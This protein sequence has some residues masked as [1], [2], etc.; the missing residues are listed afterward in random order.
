MTRHP[1]FHGVLSVSGTLGAARGFQRLLQRYLNDEWLFGNK[2]NEVSPTSVVPSM[3]EPSF[4]ELP[5]KSKELDWTRVL[6]FLV[7]QIG[8]MDVRLAVAIVVLAVVGPVL[9]YVFGY[10]EDTSEGTTTTTTTTATI[11]TTKESEIVASHLDPAQRAL[12]QFGKSKS[13]PLL[14]GY[15]SMKL[16]EI[17]E[18]RNA[19]QANLLRRQLQLE[20]PHFGKELEDEVRFA[21]RLVERQESRGREREEEIK[22]RSPQVDESDTSVGGKPDSSSR[23]EYT[24]PSAQT[25]PLDRRDSYVSHSNVCI[26]LSPIKTSNLDAQLTSE[27]A[28]S[29]PFTY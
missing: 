7:E 20:R 25:S 2:K 8:N 23:S 10:R 28:Y 1:I 6:S 16:D 22:E 21:E 26:Q 27:Q 5:E 18:N 12:L 4:E 24:L 19:E 9:P 15:V 11:T 29:Q 17:E 3:L 13:E 14:L